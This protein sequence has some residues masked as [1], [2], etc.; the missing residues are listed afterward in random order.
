MNTIGSLRIQKS[1][2]FPEFAEHRTRKS[3]LRAQFEIIFLPHETLIIVD[4]I[5]TT[6]VR[7]IF[8]HKHL[9]QWMTAAHTVK[10]LGGK[11]KLNVAWRE[12]VVAPL[13]GLGTLAAV[14]IFQP[15]ILLLTV[16]FLLGWI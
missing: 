1:K 12:M 15:A 11:L 7:L 16:P 13:F 9:L 5:L 14:I 6:L 4:A 10:I 2:E 3:W 8:T